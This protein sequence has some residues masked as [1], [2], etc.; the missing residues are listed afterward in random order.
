MAVR[1][2]MEPMKNSIRIGSI[3][4][5]DIELHFTFLLLMAIIALFGPKFFVFVLMLFFFV[6]VHE[7]S[8]SMVARAQGGK[9]K[10]IILLPIGGVA[11]VEEQPKK[12]SEEFLMSLAGPGINFVMAGFALFILHLMG[13]TYRVSY[14]LYR[15]FEFGIPSILAMTVQI[16]LLL[17]S[18]NLFVPALPM[19]GGRVLR[20]LLA[21]RMDFLKA[22]EIST[23]IAKYIAALMFLSGIYFNPWLMVISI[24]VY[25]GATQEAEMARLTSYLS[26]ITVGDVMSR[27]VITVPSGMG[28]KEFAEQIFIFKHMGY[29][30][31]EGGTMAGIVTFND[32]AAVPREEWETNTVGEVMTREVVTVSPRDDVM[33]VFQKLIGKDIGRVPVVEDSK[34]V[35]I[36]SKT[37]IIRVTQVLRLQSMGGGA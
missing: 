6:L 35:G 32:L 16:N 3:M 10:S 21:M 28:L 34:V 23:Q 17:G 22:T 9:I 2:K 13:E 14:Y 24:F 31:L 20:S 36:V 19:D 8:H 5:I 1:K 30:V 11:A 37:D 7:L 27:E 18:F 4:G 33:K 12:P 15:D 29:P 26:G 25:I